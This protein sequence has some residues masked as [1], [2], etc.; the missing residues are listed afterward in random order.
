[1]YT[2]GKEVRMV[3]DTVAAIIASLIRIITDILASM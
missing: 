2:T 3:D 1:M